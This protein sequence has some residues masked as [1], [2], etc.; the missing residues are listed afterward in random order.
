MMR[1][2]AFCFGILLGLGGLP[3][4]ADVTQAAAYCV[5]PGYPYGCVAA[6]VYRATPGVGAPGYGVTP[7]VG[8]GAPGYGVTPGA[9]VGAPGY[10]VTPGAGAPGTPYY[11]PNAGGPVNRAGMR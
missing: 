8:A 4:I 1:A 7:G 11:S 9:G 5:R 10:G 6:P 3:P 2:P